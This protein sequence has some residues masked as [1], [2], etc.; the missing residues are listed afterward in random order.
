MTDDLKAGMKLTKKV[1]SWHAKWIGAETSKQFQW[2]APHQT[3]EEFLRD[4]N[5]DTMLTVDC[6]NLHYWHMV[7]FGH[8]LL[9]EHRADA[10][11]F[12]LAARYAHATVKLEEAFS[13]ADRGGSILLTDA[14]FFFSLNVLAG[15]PAEAA[16]VGDA[17]YKGLETGLLDLCHTERH[18]KGELFR[19]FWFVVQL[20]CDSRDLPLNL[21]RYSYPEAMSP[22]A[23]A[24]A[25]WRT[26]DLGKVERWVSAMADFHLHEART[27]AH[28]QIAEFDVEE[29]MLFPYEILT[30]LRL[31]EWAGLANPKSF[32]HPLMKLPTAQLPNPVPL[33]QPDTPLLDA[34]V[35]KFKLEFPGSFQP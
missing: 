2:E 34:V 10:N 9:N 24:L 28:D 15:W 11:E 6:Q 3:F 12:A 19:H 23:D 18:S 1:A 27:V 7:H 25:D 33:P 22:Y 5:N 26:S 13:S 30:W 32:D 21:P 8:K 17:L 29:R 35:A 14:A 31:R 20:Y 16:S 4:G